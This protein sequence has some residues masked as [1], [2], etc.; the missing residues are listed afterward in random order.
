MHAVSDSASQQECGLRNVHSICKVLKCEVPLQEEF[1]GG[2]NS[3]SASKL[4]D[5]QKGWSS[6]SSL[7]VSSSPTDASLCSNPAHHCVVHSSRQ[8]TAC[9]RCL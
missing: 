9:I 6:T 4:D 7:A 1:L 5:S 8:W 3:R 2:P